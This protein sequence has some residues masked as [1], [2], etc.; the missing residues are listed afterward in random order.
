MGNVLIER[1]SA[2]FKEIESP[3]RAVSEIIY[4]RVSVRLT[5]DL[6]S[7]M[8]ELQHHTNATS[9]SEVIRRAILIYHTLVKQ[10]LKGN[11]AFI[12]VEENGTIKRVP[13]FL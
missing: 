6:G 10:K 9:P 11:E 12:E 4:P 3:L 8:K 5:G 1:Q 2:D 7:A 13:I